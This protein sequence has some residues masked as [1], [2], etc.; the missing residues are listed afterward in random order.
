M[1]AGAMK[2]EPIKPAI[3]S[4][5]DKVV[6]IRRF[7]IRAAV[8]IDKVGRIVLPNPRAIDFSFGK[9][10]KAGRATTFHASQGRYLA[11]LGQ[12]TS[13]P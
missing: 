12:G 7:L 1:T 8:K 9:D 6:G 13:R 11:S 10:S 4:V 5:R 3:R 2:P